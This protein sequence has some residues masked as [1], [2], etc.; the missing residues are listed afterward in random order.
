MPI[1]DIFR[2]FAPCSCMRIQPVGDNAGVK[3][4]VKISISTTCCRKVKIINIH[5]SPDNIDTLRDVKEIIDRIENN[6]ITSK[7]MEEN[8]I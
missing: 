4:T 3:E 6:A 5:V 7:L 2:R 8:N 1:A